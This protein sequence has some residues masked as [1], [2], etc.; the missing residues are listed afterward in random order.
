MNTVLDD[1]K[2]LCLMSGEIV[3]MSMQMNLIFEV[4][5]LAVASP[6]TVSRCG[7][8]YT[9][10]SQIGWHPLKSS[11]LK[12]IKDNFTLLGPSDM[13]MIE[14][15]LNWL[16]DPCID[17]VK[18]HCKEPIPTSPI[19]LAQSALNM[20]ECMLDE[21]KVPEVKVR[22]GSGVETD[23]GDSGSGMAAPTGGDRETWLQCLML[24]SIVWS[25]AA[26]MDNEGRGKFD[27]FYR[28]LLTQQD[29][30]GYEL[31]AGFVV[32]KPKFAIILQFP[33]V[34]SVFSYTFSKPECT[35]KLW[36]DTA[37]KRGPGNDAQYNDIIVATIDTAR[38]AFFLVLLITHQVH[39]LLGGPT[40]TGWFFT[41][42]PHMWMFIPLFVVC[43]LIL[44]G[45]TR[46]KFLFIYKYI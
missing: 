7:M 6:A 41:S 28:A 43:Y 22:R 17:F 27:G 2:K 23:Q 1:N 5:D 10:P 20:F 35:W 13:A 44:L 46:L 19:N 33:E 15:L 32:Q 4:Q 38:Y 9:E 36:M 18:K 39:V 30:L 25:I 26:S 24:I 14:S 29:Y 45:F 40:G 11:W 37:D 42:I 21:F 31:S 3:Q 16:V 34:N 12:R 8:V